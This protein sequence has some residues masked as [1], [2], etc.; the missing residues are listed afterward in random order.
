MKS[1]KSLEELYD[2]YRK[3]S[4]QRSDLKGK[5]NEALH[6]AFI[7]DHFPNSIWEFDSICL[8]GQILFE[9]KFQDNKFNF[10]EDEIRLGCGDKIWR[11]QDKLIL[12]VYNLKRLVE[13]VEK[14]KLKI[15][16]SDLNKIKLENELQSC[17]LISKQ[18]K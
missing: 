7:K 4:N 6:K 2:E 3:I 5:I 11:K 1:L 8:A 12:S 14:Y 17:F 15:I 9:S 10:L 18:L 13:Y 16:I